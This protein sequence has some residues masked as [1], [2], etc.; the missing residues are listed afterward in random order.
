M[1]V[2]DAILIVACGVLTTALFVA[3]ARLFYFYKKEHFVCPKCGFYW[4][5]SLLRMI[6]S[7][8]AVEGKV[9]YC[10]ACHVKVYVEPVKDKCSGK[11]EK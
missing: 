4:K 9:L 8:N 7:T 10:P 11:R 2:E 3:A 5:P 1:R 6:A